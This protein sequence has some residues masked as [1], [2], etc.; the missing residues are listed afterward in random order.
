MEQQLGG[1]ATAEAEEVPRR[2]DEPNLTADCGKKKQHG[3]GDRTTKE[4]MYD[5]FRHV[6]A[7]V[8]QA[9]APAIHLY[10]PWDGHKFLRDETSCP[11]CSTPRGTTNYAGKGKAPWRKVLYEEQPYEDNY[12]DKPTFLIGLITNANKREYDTVMLVIDSAAVTA[13]ISI[14]ALFI[15]VFIAIYNESVSLQLTLAGEALLLIAGFVLRR[16]IDPRFTEKYLLRG[17]R[18]LVVLVCTLFGLSPVLKTLVESVSNDTIWAL[19]IFFFV[20]H[21]AFADY[22]YLQGNAERMSAPV[23]LNAAIFASVLLGSRLS[24]SMQVFTLLCFAVLIFALFPMI[25]HHVKRKSLRCHLWLTWGMVAIVTVCLFNVYPLV[26]YAYTSTIVFTTFICP[27][28]LK[29][30]QRYKYEINGPWDEAVP[31]V[32]NRSDLQS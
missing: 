9:A 22:S 31:A 27:M 24:G 4:D 10:C 3:A 25:R 29:W 16:V 26:A 13:Q 15:L 23:S 18:S 11:E 19:T 7:A 17:V 5:R 32:E 2:E 6:S 14:I 28:W 8:H 21:L 1:V 20:L 12:T 30:M